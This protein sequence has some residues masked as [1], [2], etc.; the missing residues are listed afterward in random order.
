[1]VTGISYHDTDIEDAEE[2]DEDY[3]EEGAFRNVDDDAGKLKF[4][5]KIR[6]ETATVGF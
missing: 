2:D 1:M 3:N 4:D 5:P 6:W